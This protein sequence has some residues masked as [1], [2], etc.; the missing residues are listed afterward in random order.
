M[1]QSNIKKNC[2]IPPISFALLN[3]CF[4]LELTEV[5][6]LAGDQ[7]PPDEPDQGRRG[8]PRPRHRRRHRQLETLSQQ[9]QIS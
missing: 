2:F 5:F 7:L 9:R 1:K 6:E 4:Y 8:E 3:L